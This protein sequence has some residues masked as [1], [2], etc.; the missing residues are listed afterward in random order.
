MLLGVRGDAVPRA[1]A[2]LEQPREVFAESLGGAPS[3][4][5]SMSQGSQEGARTAALIPGMLSVLLPRPDRPRKNQLCIS[6]PECEE[7]ATA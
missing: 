4:S 1:P 5:G 2:S 6:I 7:C 3:P